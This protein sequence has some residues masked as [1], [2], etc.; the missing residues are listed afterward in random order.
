MDAPERRERRD[1]EEGARGG[2]ELALELERRDALRGL[3][4]A[5]L[6]ACARVG[7]RVG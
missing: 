5:H 7:G 6:V 3:A 4:E 1:D 2:G